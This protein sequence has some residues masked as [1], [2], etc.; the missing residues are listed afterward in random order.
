MFRWYK[1]AWVCFAYLSD[2]TE[3]QSSFQRSRWFSRGWTL[4]EL[5]AP[6]DIVFFDHQWQLAGTKETRADDLSMITGIPTTILDHS[7]ELNDIP[8]AQRFS[9]ASTR[10]TTREEDMAYS[11]LG[12][13][14]I[15]MAMLYG[16]GPKAFIRLQ[17]QIVSQSADMSIFLWT[18][19]QTSRLFTG[20]LAP[21]PACFIE[22]RHVTAEPSFTQR[23][24]HLTNRG[25]RMKLGI[26][27]EAETG[28]VILPVKHLLGTDA[29]LS[30]GVYL[31][32]VGMDLYTRAR[33]QVCTI[34]KTERFHTTLTIVKSL[35]ASQSAAI[36]SNVMRVSIPRQISLVRVEPRGSWNP[37][38]QLIH[39]AHTGAFL[40]YMEFDFGSYTK[41]AVPFCFRN[42]HWSAAVMR[43]Q[44]WSEVQPSFYT[45]PTRTFRELKYNDMMD[46]AKMAYIKGPLSTAVTVNLRGGSATEKPCIELQF[47]ER[48]SFSSTDAYSYGDGHDGTYASA[49]PHRYRTS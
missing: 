40:G 34:V 30:A 18:D 9:W 29:E 2:M 17:E 19:L 41:F 39:A 3:S 20:L 38:T 49:Q 13:F 21:S 7:V 32:N 23:E 14:D 28:L 27:W 36:E 11:L 10:Q 48:W 33:P 37:G 25:I 42:G 47:C 35:T 43:P 8:I 46:V 15:N 5:I 24:F 12:I 26:A 45:N 16:E 6:K 4:Q 1:D 22:M 44:R 31:R